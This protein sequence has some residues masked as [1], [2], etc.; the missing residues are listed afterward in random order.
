MAA[1]VIGTNAIQIRTYASAAETELGSISS[2]LTQLVTAC[3]T[4]P[5]WGTNGKDFKTKTGS[6]AVEMSTA[7]NT[8][9]K[10]FIGQVNTANKAIA[11]TL[12]GDVTIDNVPAPTI[13][14]PTIGTTG[15]GGETGEGMHPTAL[16]D[17][18]T[19]VNGLRTKIETAT[20]NHSAALNSTPEWQGNQKE[21]ALLGCKAFKDKVD[22]A[23]QAGF[24]A[25]NDAIAA[26]HAA[27]TSADA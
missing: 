9:M 16:V 22:A 5:Y 25:I 2:S 27:T 17:L 23:V 1:P 24:K 26:Q 6:N 8:A 14:L 21:S 15:P 4:V 12:G 11:N 18:Q 20:T 10:T 7:I 19:T 3:T 13:D